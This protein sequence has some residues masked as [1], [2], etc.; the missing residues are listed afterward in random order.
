VTAPVE[1]WAGDSDVNVPFA[2]NVGP[3]LRAL[4]VA[5]TSMSENGE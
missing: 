1:L 5:G 4:G 2:S 3:V